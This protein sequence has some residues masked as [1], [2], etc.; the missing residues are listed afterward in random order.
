MGV[1]MVSSAKHYPVCC[2]ALS[3]FPRTRVFFMCFLCVFYVFVVVSRVILVVECVALSVG[4][5]VS[6]EHIPGRRVF[7][8]AQLSSANQLAIQSIK[9]VAGSWKR[10]LE[11]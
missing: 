4:R 7:V 9:Y 6:I 5:S 3:G 10:W 1:E 11:G 2:C 8:V